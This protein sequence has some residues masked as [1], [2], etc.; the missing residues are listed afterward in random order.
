MVCLSPAMSAL[1]VKQALLSSR[2]DWKKKQ[3]NM[4]WW[5][6]SGVG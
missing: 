2:L 5:E 3:L 4:V 1:A 6:Q